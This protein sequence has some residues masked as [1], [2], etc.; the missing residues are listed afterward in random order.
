MQSLLQILVIN[1]KAI[2]AKGDRK[3]FDLVEAECLL[4]N[5]DGTPVKVGGLRIPE[6]LKPVAKP[7]IF[8][9]TFALEVSWKDRSIGAVLS[10][11]RE[12]RKTEKG[13]VPVDLPKAV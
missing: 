2:A 6:V 4:L 5:D 3:A 9:G 8:L 7:G 10:G 11:L 12:V 1:T 13:F